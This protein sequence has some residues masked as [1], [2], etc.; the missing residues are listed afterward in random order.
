MNAYISIVELQSSEGFF[1]AQALQLVNFNPEG[2]VLDEKQ[3]CTVAALFILYKNF[4]SS[5][6]EWK[7]VAKKAQVWLRK[8]GLKEKWDELA[9]KL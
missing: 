8:S 4:A 7:L 6:Q 3:L 9:E 1:N 5:E 2:S